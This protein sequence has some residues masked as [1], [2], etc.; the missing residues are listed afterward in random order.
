[1]STTP[2]APLQPVLK[3]RL[4][5]VGG[6]VPPDIVERPLFKL[7]GHPSL[8]HPACGASYPQKSSAPTT[9]W[10]SQWVKV[11]GTFLLEATYQAFTAILLLENESSI[12]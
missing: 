12:Q 1:M 2:P 11:P 9:Q 7:N 4:A 8:P 10:L 3:G 6:P 5:L